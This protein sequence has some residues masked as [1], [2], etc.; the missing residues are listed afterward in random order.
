MWSQFT[1]V[2]DRRTDGRTD[3]QTT[4]DGN[5]ALCTKVH[6]AVKRDMICSGQGSIWSSRCV[7]VTPR[8]HTSSHISSQPQADI[9]SPVASVV[10]KVWRR[11]Q[12][13]NG[14]TQ[15]SEIR[16]GGLQG[17][18]ETTD[19]RRPETQPNPVG[20]SV[21]KLDIWD[22]GEGSFQWWKYLLSVSWPIPHICEVS[23]RRLQG[24]KSKNL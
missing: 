9:A 13:V 21:L 20:A 15:V 2:T 12:F 1:N 3:R 16:S 14:T 19:D 4:C 23:C 7:D 10:G 24:E 22:V 8:P 11:C 5:T 18:Q 17:T 6:R